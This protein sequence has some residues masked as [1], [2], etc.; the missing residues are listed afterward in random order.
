MEIIIP[1]LTPPGYSDGHCK[2]VITRCIDKLNSLGGGYSGSSGGFGGWKDPSTGES[3]TEPH[4]K[5]NVDFSIKRWSVGA[6]E[7]RSIILMIQNELLQQCVKLTF[8][9]APISG[10]INLLGKEVN[11]FPSFEEFGE[12]DSS[13]LQREVIDAYLV[14]NRSEFI[15][16]LKKLVTNVPE[17]KPKVTSR[18]LIE[19]CNFVT[20]N[21]SNELVLVTG[22]SGC[23]KSTQL[24]MIWDNSN[25]DLEL[26]LTSGR[27][28]ADAF[29]DTS[30]WDKL[31]NKLKIGKPIIVE[32]VCVNTHSSRYKEH[33]DAIFELQ[34]NVRSPILVVTQTNKQLGKLLRKNAVQIKTEMTL[35]LAD[36]HPDSIIEQ[37]I[38]FHDVAIEKEGE[39]ILRGALESKRFTARELSQNL[40]LHRG[41]SIGE[42]TI[43]SW[44]NSS[45]LIENFLLGVSKDDVARILALHKVINQPNVM[46][47][48]DIPESYVMKLL[49]VPKTDLIEIGFV[50]DLRAK[51][52]GLKAV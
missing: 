7:L 18:S 48:R 12:P 47:R 24:S 17:I 38:D 20:E 34:Q 49:G 23:G 14:S 10:P 27:N 4:V 29:K 28:L 46:M 13:F 50:E 39:L 43:S 11:S 8:N 31:I 2:T 30:R 21:K 42:K 41:G 52:C 6:D 22:R 1:I 9:G 26:F 35:D 40:N 37:I 51:H 3:P 5:L 15:D 19:I 44:E 32:D 36:E 25:S 45:M 16:A 33:V